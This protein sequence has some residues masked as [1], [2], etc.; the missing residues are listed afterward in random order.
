[1]SLDVVTALGRLLS[2]GSQRASF[3]ADREA[4][5][6][7]LDLEDGADLLRGLDAGEL[8]AQARVLLEKRASEVAERLPRTRP[9]LGERFA[10]LFAQFAQTGW[11]RGHLR[12]LHDARAFLRWLRQA[13][14]EAPH[15]LDELAVEA[16]LARREGRG[17]TQAGFAHH[18]DLPLSSAFLAVRFGGRRLRLLLPLP[19]PSALGRRWRW[20]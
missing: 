12:H 17:R 7:A 6:D 18:A 1:M 14:P 2:D 19:L 16:E 3:V 20:R 10:E 13:A 5:L 15:S 4:W 11:P 8:E 9:R